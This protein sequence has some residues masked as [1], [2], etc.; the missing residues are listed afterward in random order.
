MADLSGP[1]FRNRAVAACVEEVKATP[2]H[3]Y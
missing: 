2:G 3:G 1:D